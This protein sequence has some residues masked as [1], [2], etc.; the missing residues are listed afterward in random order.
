MNATTIAAILRHLLGIASGFLV[1]KGID[2]D[3]GSIEIISG[4]LGSLVAV[5]WSLKQKKD[6]AKTP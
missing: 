4:A 2:L 3:S 1:A 6:A 5:A